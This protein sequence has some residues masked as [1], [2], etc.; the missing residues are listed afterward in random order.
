MSR[1]SGWERYTSEIATYF[2][3]T[4]G[5][6]VWRERPEPLPRRLYS[7]LKASAL[8]KDS[9]VHFPTFPPLAPHRF[10][11]TVLTVHD[12]TWWRYPET[13]S[14]LGRLY[15]RPLLERAIDAASMIVTHT[16]SVADEVCEYFGVA[17]ERVVPVYCGAD[18]ASLANDKSSEGAPYLLAVGTLEPRK[19]LQ[20]LVDA[21]LQS[22]IRHDV[23]LV[24]VGRV[25]WGQVPAGVTVRSGVDDAELQALYRGAVALVLPSIYEGFGLPIVESLSQ[26]TPV[27]CSDL[28]VFREVSLGAATFFDPLSVE[29]IQSALDG[30]TSLTRPTQREI[31]SVQDLYSWSSVGQRLL[32]VYDMVARGAA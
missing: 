2:D 19:N 8:P 15:Y 22:S 26:G 7:D 31:E 24:I 13:A 28:R 27:L 18:S 29:S 21:Y 23:D 9:I 30:A 4:S 10:K 5:V 25:A 6:S 11:G 14:R 12:L 20:R 32:G 1:M 16:Q 17:P 3:A